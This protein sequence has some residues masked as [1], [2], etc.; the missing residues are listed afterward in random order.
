[1]CL[2][3][4]LMC[5]F[6][7]FTGILSLCLSSIHQPASLPGLLCSPCWDTWR[8]RK[9][10][11]S[12]TSLNLVKHVVCIVIFLLLLGFCFSVLFSCTF[13]NIMRLYDQRHKKRRRRRR[14]KRERKKKR[15][16]REEDGKLIQSEIHTKVSRSFVEMKLFNS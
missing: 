5:P 9:M 7:A 10:Y 3:V 16:K 8:M 2:L 12:K 6:C 1:M 11:Q 14:K 13:F 4:R 15:K